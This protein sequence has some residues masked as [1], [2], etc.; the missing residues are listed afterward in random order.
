M[1]HYILTAAALTVL[2]ALSPVPTDACTTAIVGAKASASGRPMMWKQRDAGGPGNVAAYVSETGSFAFTGIFNSDDKGH[3]N[4]W[5]GINERGFAIMNNQSYNISEEKYKA[6]NGAV[7]KKALQTC[8]TI[9]EF[10]KM[11]RD[12][13]HPC[14]T[15][16]NFGVID[17]TG[18]AAYIEAGGSA[19]N[20]FD[21][22]EDGWLV[23]TNYSF[24]GIEGK[25]SGYARYETAQYI[26]AHHKGK[27]KAEDLIDGLGRSFRNQVLGRDFLK[28]RRTDFVWDEDFIPRPTTRSSTCIEG[29]IPG[30]RPDSGLMWIAPGYAP[31]CYSLPVWVAA[32]DEIP[33]CLTANADGESEANLLAHR[34]QNS[35]HTLMRD[36]VT[37]YIDLRVIR[38]I[39][40][41]TRAAEAVEME[42]GRELDG[43]FRRTGLDI[44]AVRKYNAAAA[45]RFEDYRKTSE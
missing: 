20:R 10:E 43:R 5:A 34:L 11:L 7:M 22:P 21:V 27:F 36:A 45:A 30:D 18:A 39:L 12:I 14:P 1:K 35:A 31:A 33:S 38:T 37:K 42:A 40:K 6:R 16:A 4:V 32:K 44:E 2:L 29:V 8:T 28:G 24:S 25:G 9:D 26:M 23:R 41:R 13:P 19:I 17:A 15:K 3:K